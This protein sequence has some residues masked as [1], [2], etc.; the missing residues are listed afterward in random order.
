MERNFKN[1]DEIVLEE[2]SREFYGIV[3]TECPICKKPNNTVPTPIVKL[4]NVGYCLDC[5]Y[6]EI[7]K[8][9]HL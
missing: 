9:S 6:K 1:V 7:L 8:G 4:G 3:N 5:Y 2:D